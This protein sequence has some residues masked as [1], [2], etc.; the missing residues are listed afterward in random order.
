M[1]EISCDRRYAD[2]M[3]QALYNGVLSGVS[4]SGDRFFYANRL[5]IVP[6]ATHGLSHHQHAQRQP[7]F[8]CACC[9]PNLARL[10]AALGSYIYAVADREVVV[11]LYTQ[12]TATAQLEGGSVRISQ[13]TAY[14][15]KERVDLEIAPEA[16]HR[17]AISLR[18]PSWCTGAKVEVNGEPVDLPAVT[19]SGY[20]RIRRRWESGDRVRLTLP[21]KP[22]R[23]Y[24]APEVRSNAGRVALRRGPLVYCFEQTD[25]GADLNALSLPRRAALRS[26][27]RPDLLG[28]VVAL[29]TVGRRLRGSVGLYQPSPPESEEASL[30][31]VP[32]YAWANRRAGEMLV[33][34]RE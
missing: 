30:Q 5:A 32:Y 11:H 29:E 6:R 17:F 22:E 34:I 3:E 2:V 28:G 25:N 16:P 7:W 18:V 9:P 20:A 13:R 31:A 1:L 4:L 26:R 27:W 15:W 21:M 8:G 10:I 23:V 14:P 24:A 19:R 12:S 33:W